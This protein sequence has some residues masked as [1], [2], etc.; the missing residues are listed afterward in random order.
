[1]ARGGEPDRPDALAQSMG[2]F[3]PWQIKLFFIVGFFAIPTCYPVLNLTFMNATNDF[4]C[5][6][7][8]DS[9]IV[10]GG[11]DLDQSTSFWLVANGH[12]DHVLRQQGLNAL[13][14]LDQANALSIQIRM[15][16]RAFELVGALE[17]VAVQVED[18]KAASMVFVSDGERRAGHLV[19]INALRPRNTLHEMGFAGTQV[20]HQA[21]HRSR[22]Q[23]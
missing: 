4:W 11:K 19:R 22:A 16:S 23:A 18:G 9:V 10:F 5:V 20:S 13:R 8:D 21:H 1:M 12:E 6:S 14:P 17:T 3:G 7:V 15:R 2:E